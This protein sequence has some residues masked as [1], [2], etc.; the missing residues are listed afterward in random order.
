[1]NVFLTADWY[2]DI[3]LELQ[4]LLLVVDMEALGGVLY[5]A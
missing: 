5:G 3:G 2:L 1:M 4:L